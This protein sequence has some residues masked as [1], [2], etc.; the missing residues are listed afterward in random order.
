MG[1][2][3]AQLPAQLGA[4]AVEAAHGIVTSGAPAEMQNIA[5][6]LELVTNPAC[7]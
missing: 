2:T 5:V 4:Q 7:P 3:V 6:G 1:A